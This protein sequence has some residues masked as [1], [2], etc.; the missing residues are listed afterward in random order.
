MAAGGKR[1]L[2]HAI[3]NLAAGNIPG[4]TAAEVGRCTLR[5]SYPDGSCAYW[6]VVNA[7]PAFVGESDAEKMREI[8]R[9]KGVVWEEVMD[10]IFGEDWENKKQDEVTK[11]QSNSLITNCS[12]VRRIVVCAACHDKNAGYEAVDAVEL[13]F[14]SR[15][16]R[17]GASVWIDTTELEEGSVEK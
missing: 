12:N 10:L 8:S 3:K 9:L 11:V 14:C 1:L 5:P 16:A 17:E 7:L 15:H 6:S 13:F 4:L 2:Q